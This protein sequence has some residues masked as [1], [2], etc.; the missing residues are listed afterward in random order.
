[1]KRIIFYFILFATVLPMCAQDRKVTPVDVDEKKPPGPTLHYYDKHG[2]PLDEPVLF[3]ADIDTVKNVSAKP[4]YPLLNEVSIGAN[5]FDGI[6]KIAGQSYASFDVWGALSLHNWVFPVVEAGIGFA[7]NTPQGNNFSYH[8]KPSLYIK[9]GVNYNFLYKSNPDYKV[10]LGIRA[11]FSSFSYNIKDITIS[12]GY[13]G[14]TNNFDILSQKGS[15]WYGEALAG[16]QVKI[17]GPISLGWTFRYHFKM[18]V[19][20][21]SNSI[22]WF[23]PGYGAKSPITATFSVIYSIPLSRKIH[24]DAITE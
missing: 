18:N 22:P 6:L 10:F 1:M 15:A 11:G 24:P 12:D 9:A 2:E 14:E 5:F 16:L 4:V 19:K 8:C 3:L 13:W 7:D 17:A 23:I 20:N 21:G